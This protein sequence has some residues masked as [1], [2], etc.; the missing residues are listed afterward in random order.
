[1]YVIVSDHVCDPPPPT[2]QQ[3]FKVLFPSSLWVWIDQTQRFSLLLQ[4]NL[5][6]LTT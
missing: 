1:M 5:E 2:A 6:L 3:S 4:L